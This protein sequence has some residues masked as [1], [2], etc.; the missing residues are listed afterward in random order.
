MMLLKGIVLWYDVQKRPSL[1]VFAKNFY[2]SIINVI[3]IL[4]SG[5][6]ALMEYVPKVSSHSEHLRDYDDGG[7]LSLDFEDTLDLEETVALMRN[8]VLC[9]ETAGI[10]H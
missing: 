10:I 9:S 2:K 7:W 8:K 4:E 1:Y 6:G 3:A 5:R